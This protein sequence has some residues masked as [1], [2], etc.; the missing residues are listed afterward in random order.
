VTVRPAAA[1]DVPAMHALRLSVRENKLSDPSRV[2]PADYERRL[3]QSGAGWVA[4]VGDSL[5]GFAIADFASRSIWA[6]FVMP[7][8]EGRGIGRALLHQ[9]TRSL[10]AAGPGTIHLSTDAGTRAE[11]LYAA[12]GW[13]Q[14][15]RLPNGELHFVREVRAT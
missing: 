1:G 4:E 7:G 8:M 10:E 3:T 15:G 5:A 2:T 9:V 13:I 11:R 14:A 12:A 6:L